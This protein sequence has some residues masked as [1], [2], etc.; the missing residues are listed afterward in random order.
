MKKA[1][2]FYYS[3][4]HGNTEKVAEEIAN[5]LPVDLVR[6]PSKDPVNLEG[7]DLVGFASGIYMS[8]FGKPVS[9]FAEELDGLA[10]KPCFTI[11][12]CGAPAG[13]FSGPFAELLKRKGVQIAGKWHCRGFDTYGPFKLIG[14]LAKG[15]PD[16]ADF[17]SA[18]AFVEELL[19]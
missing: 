2:L 5:K 11:Y 6:I 4:H 1:V 19:K 17:E 3:I 12:T 9:H 15:R 18:V 10:G 8:E 7:Y 16:K 14:G 13:E